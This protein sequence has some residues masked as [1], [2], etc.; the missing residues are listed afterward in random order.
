MPERKRKNSNPT[1]LLH[2]RESFE[3]SSK[4]KK[5]MGMNSDRL[6]TEDEQSPQMNIKKGLRGK[7]KEMLQ[8]KPT[9]KVT[10]MTARRKSEIGVQII[11]ALDYLMEEP[12]YCNNK[13]EN[14]DLKYARSSFPLDHFIRQV[15]SPNVSSNKTN[16]TS[17]S[18]TENTLRTSLNDNLNSIQKPENE[19]EN[20][21]EHEQQII[22]PPLKQPSFI[23][24]DH[25][26]QSMTSK[27]VGLGLMHV[28]FDRW[29]QKTIFK[30]EV[31][32]N[33]IFF[34][35]FSSVIRDHILQITNQS[36]KSSDFI[37]FIN[38]LLLDD[39]N[40][41]LSILDE[42]QLIDVFSGNKT[43]Q[44][45]SGQSNFSLISNLGEL[46]VCCSI[47]HKNCCLGTL[48][49]FEDW[50]G[51]ITTQKILGRRVK[52]IDCGTFHYGIITDSNEIILWGN[53]ILPGESKTISGQQS[54]DSLLLSPPKI[55]T[56]IPGKPLFIRCGLSH[57]IIVTS[58]GLF[59]FG[60]NILGQLGRPGNDIE[61]NST[62]LPVPGIVDRFGV[63]CVIGD[64]ACGANHTVVCTEDGLVF[65]WGDNH[66]GQLGH[67]QRLLFV[68]SPTVLNDINNIISVACGYSHSVFLDK[69]GKLYT[70][71]S[72][73]FGELGMDPNSPTTT[74]STST[75]STLSSSQ[76]SPGSS[77]SSSQFQRHH[78]SLPHPI[79]KISTG[80]Y[81]TICITEIGTVYQWGLL[82]SKNMIQNQYTPRLIHSL[83][84]NK[85]FI[86]NVSSGITHNLYLSD[87]SMSELL[88]TLIECC[89]SKQTFNSSPLLQQI[90][91]LP[92]LSRSF[93]F[94]QKRALYEC[95]NKY[96]DSFPILLPEK[97]YF[98]VEFGESRKSGYFLL[99]LKNLND[100]SIRVRFFGSTDLKHGKSENVVIEPDEFKISKRSERQVKVLILYMQPPTEKIYGMIHFTV[101]K[102]C[103]TS[104]SSSKSSSS[105]NNN[106]N[107]N[108]NRPFNSRN[109]NSNN[110]FS[111]TNNNHPISHCFVIYASVPKKRLTQ[112]VHKR[113]ESF[114]SLQLV[115]N[116]GTYVP[117]VLLQY[118]SKNPN[119]PKKPHIQQFPAAILFLDISGFTSLNER[120]AQLGP[121]GPELVSK[122]INSYFASLIKAV[123][124]H[125]GDVLKF[126]GD[127]LI[128]MWSGSM[129][130]H[131]SNS[132]SAS[133][134]SISTQYS[135]SSFSSIQYSQS[136]DDFTVQND[137]QRA[138]GAAAAAA[139][140]MVMD[141]LTWLTLRAIQCGFDIQTRL[142]KYDSNEGFS[143]TLHIGVGSGE[144]L[145]LWAGSEGSYEYL[146]SGE[147]LAQLRTAVDNSQTGEVVISAECWNLVQSYCKGEPRGNDFWVSEI[148]NQVPITRTKTIKGWPRPDAEAALRCFIPMAVQV[149][150]DSQQLQGWGNELRCA[151][152]LFVKLNT[153]IPNDDK[154]I[155][156]S[157][158]NKV[159]CSMQQAI[160]KYEGMVRQFLAD[161]KGTVLIAA[162]G[163]PPFCHIE[164]PLRGINAALEIYQNLKNFNM[165]CSIGITT[166]QV[167]CGSVGCPVRQEYAMVGDVVNLSARLMI[168]AFKQKVNILCDQPT[169]ESS[170]NEISFKKLDPIMVKGK[171]NPIPI[172]LPLIKD[173]KRKSRYRRHK[174]DILIGRDSEKRFIRDFLFK[175]H[176]NPLK[177]QSLFLSLNISSSLS[178]SSSNTSA[179]S[180]SSLF[181]S[182]SKNSTP[183]STSCLFDLNKQQ[184][185]QQQ[186]QNLTYSS[187][188]SRQHQNIRNLSLT[189]GSVSS[190]AIGY[191]NYHQNNYSVHNNGRTLIIHS[192]QGI[193]KSILC[194]YAMKLCKRK[195]ILIC[196][197][198]GNHFQKN[199][200]FFPWISMV[201]DLFGIT[202][203]FSRSSNHA[204]QLKKQICSNLI[205]ILPDNWHDSIPL[206]NDLY[207]FPPSVVTPPMNSHHHPH[208]VVDDL[209]VNSSNINFD[210]E[211]F[212][213]ENDYTRSLSK[214][215]RLYNLSFLLKHIF[216]EFSNHSISGTGHGGGGG[217]GGGDSSFST[218]SDNTATS[219]SHDSS[220]TC[221]L[222]TSPGSSPNSRTPE[223][224]NLPIFYSSFIIIAEDLQWF[225]S[226]SLSLLLSVIKEIQSITVIISTRNLSI[227]QNFLQFP[228]VYKLSLSLLSE[229]D[230]LHLSKRI[231]HV[232]SLPDSISSLFRS[233]CGN[234]LLVREIASELLES[235]ILE[236]S[237]R[238][239]IITGNL[240][241]VTLTSVLAIIKAKLD[242]LP[243]GQQIV[244]K[245]GSY[246]FFFYFFLLFSF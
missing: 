123:S 57:T 135:H 131:S 68:R 150:L 157:T 106:V 108:N 38:K 193:G 45:S 90:I 66:F 128:C 37:K 34:N 166:G 29:W 172:Y 225:D 214:E 200:P 175:K 21:H 138:G 211:N 59:S 10:A 42:L 168:A 189:T 105:S 32:L 94:L 102:G 232:D 141:D 7:F 115:K 112:L 174:C 158:I 95:K 216:N 52:S 64:I 25:E 190:N 70:M 122:H 62:P 244:L 217:G 56:D 111:F 226:D 50:G 75:T 202:N 139:P 126:A 118:M 201:K 53:N 19:N 224:S 1:K 148:T 198:E 114:G 4:A 5:L 155:Y 80:A 147:P 81:N 182:K 184:Q 132:S 153:D 6:E 229:E 8:K 240:S 78:I 235:G 125:G 96:S 51:S 241:D 151:T 205:T 110:S 177:D 134:P 236:V 43:V 163:L 99:T 97:S 124:E 73:L 14:I 49:N 11:K 245:V 12:Y 74:T 65:S 79:V 35:S 28:E 47:E 82:R 130:N 93:E 27:P 16:S 20:H 237:N 58:N 24:L 192:P 107:N 207:L 183:Q 98:K 41:N 194:N 92:N 120:L 180:N 230:I 164:D 83:I 3:S 103:K 222:S 40:K 227:A 160:F 23:G 72:N 219:S 140:M 187:G 91:T 206:L 188:I 48:Q 179:A 9:D 162:F 116:L 31:F 85:K 87:I 117:S 215:D 159:L 144:L 204:M 30:G 26:E 242:R 178:N 181:K 89:S 60:S 18:S 17:S 44:I 210:N 121:A 173:K 238:K 195:K 243:S 13:I 67:S 170:N 146:V 33:G 234:P 228:F 55:I 22:Q 109:S 86:V 119:P 191:S 63:N 213:E 77:S 127:A 209:H 221:T 220:D 223:R 154:E 208:S 15:N 212:I 156:L 54:S 239:C 69:D 203:V 133:I 100:F 101:E 104:S 149:S 145:S 185:Q 161:D 171:K 113:E 36:L 218:L 152:I 88:P 233:T 76:G 142:D 196:H 137:E 167:Y 84:E 246:I 2:A 71:G 199:S 129:N 46:H 197:G 176:F 186:Q 39:K 169:Y 143:L 231:L 61:T 165:D 136:I